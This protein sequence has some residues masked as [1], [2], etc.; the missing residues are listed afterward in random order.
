MAEENS[1]QSEVRASK[2]YPT[3]STLGWVRSMYEKVDFIFSHYSVNQ[4]HATE[5]FVENMRSLTYTTK[6]YYSQPSALAN[7]IKDDLETILKPYFD[8]VHIEVT[9]KQHVDEDTGQTL[10]EYDYEIAMTIRQGEYQWKQF[11]GVHMK[12]SKMEVL[13]GINYNGDRYSVAGGQ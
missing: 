5:Q 4:R 2:P 6:T 12:E 8:F 10:D 9:Y 3:L 13:A 7:Q 1:L 11:K